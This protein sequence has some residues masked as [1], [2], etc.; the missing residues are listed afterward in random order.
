MSLLTSVK[1][2]VTK[3]E[4]TIHMFWVKIR[5]EPN[6]ELNAKQGIKQIV[7]PNHLFV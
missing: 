7:H 5:F 4:K 6:M 2:S 1:I 3:N